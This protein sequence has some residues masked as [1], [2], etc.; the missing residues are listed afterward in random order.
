M[1]KKQRKGGGSRKI[2]RWKK[3]PA[4][5]RYLAERRWAKNKAR[6]IARYMRKHPN[7]RPAFISDDVKALL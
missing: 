5:K 1:P 6:R 2:G 4:N 7:W 3:K